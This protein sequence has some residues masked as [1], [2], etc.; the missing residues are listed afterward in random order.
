MVEAYQVR[1]EAV[2]HEVGRLSQVQLHPPMG[3]AEP[4]REDGRERTEGRKG[5]E[6]EEE[7][8]NN[9]YVYPDVDVDADAEGEYAGST[10][11]QETVRPYSRYGRRASATVTGEEEEED[12]DESE[13]EDIWL[14]IATREE[15]G[16]Q[17]L[18]RVEKRI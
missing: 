8:E 7:Y 1:C 13:V 15:K 6:A 11:S 18:R 3:I 5:K 12:Y 14:K 16:K 9:E 17:V 10:S 2:L 4:F